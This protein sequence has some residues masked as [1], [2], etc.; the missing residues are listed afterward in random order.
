M[1]V[2]NK[3]FCYHQDKKQTKKQKILFFHNTYV[4]FT[5]EN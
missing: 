3:N 2:W 1:V 4:Q 5:P